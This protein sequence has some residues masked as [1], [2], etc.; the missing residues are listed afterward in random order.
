LYRVHLHIINVINGIQR[1]N[2]IIKNMPVVLIKRKWVMYILLLW[3][4]LL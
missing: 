4:C 2:N 3:V 1:V